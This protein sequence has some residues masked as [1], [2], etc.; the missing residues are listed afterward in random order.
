MLAN[1]NAHID[2]FCFHK[3]HHF[4]GA[5]LSLTYVKRNTVT[6]NQNYVKM[7]NI[8]YKNWSYKAQSFFAPP[9]CI[10]R[11]V[12]SHDQEMLQDIMDEFG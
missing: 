8:P 9:F 1:V 5:V 6:Y 12:C 2:A 11:S 7:W 3:D 4:S 10:V